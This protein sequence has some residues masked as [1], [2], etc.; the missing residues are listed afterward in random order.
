MV[1]YLSE[2]LDRRPVFLPKLYGKWQKVIDNN[3]N[4]LDEYREIVDSLPGI[5][6]LT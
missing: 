6:A 5:Y 4:K 3:G 2:N 1:F